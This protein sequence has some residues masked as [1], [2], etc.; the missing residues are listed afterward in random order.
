MK[1]RSV[2]LGKDPT[3]LPEMCTVRLSPSLRQRDLWLSTRAT[4]HWEKGNTQAI[5][6]LLDTGPELNNPGDT[7]HHCDPSV[8]A[9]SYGSQRSPECLLVHFCVHFHKFCAGQHDCS[10][11]L[12]IILSKAPLRHLRFLAQNLPSMAS[13]RTEASL[14]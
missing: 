12:H 8:R 11:F 5:W 13:Y 14:P 7:M 2:S 10:G 4:M 6:G 3:T 1:G 9:G